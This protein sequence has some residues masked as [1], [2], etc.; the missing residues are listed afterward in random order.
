MVV[1]VT[2]VTVDTVLITFLYI[3]TEDY[4]SM[5]VLVFLIFLMFLFS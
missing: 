1:R 5:F 4:S 2:V 3:Y